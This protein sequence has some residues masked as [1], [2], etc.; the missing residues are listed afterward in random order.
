MSM[1]F[2]P[3]V[4]FQVRYSGGTATHR[5]R[6]GLNTIPECTSGCILTRTW[7]AGTPSRAAASSVVTEVRPWAS[8]WST[9]SEVQ[10]RG[11]HRFLP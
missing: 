3:G 7:L 10:V 11:I 4:T 8:S 1:K 9:A 2:S 6:A 5:P